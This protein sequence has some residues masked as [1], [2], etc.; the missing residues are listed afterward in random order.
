MVI[1]KRLWDG[2]TGQI[3][4]VGEVLDQFEPYPGFD[5]PSD[6]GSEVQPGGL[7]VNLQTSGGQEE[8]KR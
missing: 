5:S 4:E 7:D 1:R 6:C 3:I 2:A 8:R